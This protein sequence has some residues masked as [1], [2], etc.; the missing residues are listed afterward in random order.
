[1]VLTVSRGWK[2]RDRVLSVC[3]KN[4]WFLVQNIAD[5]LT[6]STNHYIRRLTVSECL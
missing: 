1:M 4:G 5:V 3:D 6:L 2:S